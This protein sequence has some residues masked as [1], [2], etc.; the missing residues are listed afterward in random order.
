M[1]RQDRGTLLM[2]RVELA[3][4][5]AAAKRA[6]AAPAGTVCFTVLQRTSPAFRLPR[7]LLK[8]SIRVLGV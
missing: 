3:E 2:Y 8:K 4:A 5:A 7:I 6:C 1:N